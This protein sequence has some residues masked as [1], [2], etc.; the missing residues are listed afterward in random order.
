MRKRIPTPY[1]FLRYPRSKRKINLADQLKVNYGNHRS[2]W[3]YAIQCLAKLHN[4]RG[5]KIDTFI[6][7]TF[8]WHPQGIKPHQEPWIGFIH[9]PPNVPD[10]FMYEQ[11]NDRIIQSE[12]FQRSVPYCRGL[13]VLSDYHKR[14]LE[15]KL[16]LPI[17]NLLFPTET[18][19]L[20]WSWKRF[21]ANSEKKIIQVGWWLR[22]LHSIF[23]LNTGQYKKIFL[24]PANPHLK[25]LLSK[26]ATILRKE[27]KVT[28]DLYHQAERIPFLDNAE[29]DLLLSKN[30]VMID[31]YDASANNTVI[32]CIA[33]NTPLLVNPIEGVVEYLGKDYPFYF[34]SL[35]EAA[36]KAENLD[37]VHQ[38]HRFLVN[39]PIKPMLKRSYFLDSFVQSEVYSGL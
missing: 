29:Y 28:S 3:S 5:V 4:P 20:K 21:E 35:D 16:D 10:W 37:L 17:N 12:A 31:L 27:R 38:A 1:I 33:R 23:L 8:F 22:K 9:V 24:D 19:R 14:S 26:E 18:P 25:A 6:E 34:E 39:H 36:A 32:E 13:F 11:S 30:I 15:K 2:G 7:R